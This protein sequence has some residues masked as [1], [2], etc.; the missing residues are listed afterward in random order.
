[1]DV[2]LKSDKKW[3]YGQM[4][5]KS[6][7]NLSFCLDYLV[8]NF[9]LQTVRS[10][11]IIFFHSVPLTNKIQTHSSTLIF[12]M[13]GIKIV[14]RCKDQLKNRNTFLTNYIHEKSIPTSMSSILHPSQYFP[15]LHKSVPWGLYSC[16]RIFQ[17]IYIWKYQIYRIWT[18][19]KTRNDSKSFSM[20]KR[21][22]DSAQC[23]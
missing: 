13:D 18:S 1:M 9:S 23:F 2:W 12:H 21:N 11:S 10:Q 17:G 22:M 6:S 5:N 19:S 20:N 7:I 3:L 14:R 15:G 4:E 8:I 16:F